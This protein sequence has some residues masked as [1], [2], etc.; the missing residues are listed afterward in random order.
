M[1]KT[2]HH[3]VQNVISRDPGAVKM[4]HSLDSKRIC[5]WYRGINRG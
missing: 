5:L 1:F 3:I 4:I 2:A